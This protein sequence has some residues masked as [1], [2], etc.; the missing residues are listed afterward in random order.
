MICW[1][2]GLAG[3]NVGFREVNRVSYGEAAIAA[4]D[5]ENF[6][7]VQDSVLVLAFLGNGNIV[8]VHKIT[9]AMGPSDLVCTDLRHLVV[10][11]DVEGSHVNLGERVDDLAE[12]ESQQVVE[13]GINGEDT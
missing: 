4:L 1:D 2:E 9:N 5:L 7:V 6:P 12:V 10:N 3:I 11:I 13:I 8:L